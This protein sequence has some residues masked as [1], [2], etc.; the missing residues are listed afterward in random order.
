MLWQPNY[1]GGNNHGACVEDAPFGQSEVWQPCL[2]RNF[3]RSITLPN[4]VTM[5]IP[6]LD[7]DINKRILILSYYSFRKISVNR[8]HGLQTRSIPPQKRSPAYPLILRN[9]GTV[10]PSRLTIGRLQLLHWIIWVGAIP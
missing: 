6:V 10:W 1:L 7:D 2:V 8:T 4:K 3:N 5:F 9:T